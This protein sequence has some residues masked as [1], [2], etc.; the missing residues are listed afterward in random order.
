MGGKVVASHEKRLFCKTGNFGLTFY[1]RLPILH[2]GSNGHEVRKPGRYQK[3][4]IRVPDK[5]YAEQSGLP[6]GRDIH[7]Y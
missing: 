2:S 5:P 4:Y 3:L 1:Y 7:D 6:S